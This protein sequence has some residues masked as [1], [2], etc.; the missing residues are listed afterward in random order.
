M[1]TIILAACA[2]SALVAG[3][4]SVPTR[5]ASTAQ[6]VAAILAFNQRYVKSIN[7]GDITT[8]SGFTTEEHVM[9][10]P[11]RPPTVGKAANDAANSRA[12]AQFRFAESWAPVETEVAGDWAWQRGTFRVLATPK[13]GGETRTMTG[14]YLHIY[15][16]QPDGSWR[17]VRDMFN[18]E[19]APATN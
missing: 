19:T 3:C 17:M 5:S 6:D 12:V 10:P 2:I 18:T 14:N 13:A 1:R 4:S 15:R 8:L 7:D 11:G 9:M 16:R